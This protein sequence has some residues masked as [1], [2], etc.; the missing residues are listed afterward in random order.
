MATLPLR[1]FVRYAEAFPGTGRKG[2]FLG[3]I[4]LSAAP[5]AWRPW[6]CVY[7]RLAKI[8]AFMEVVRYN[9]DSY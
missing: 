5:S 3:E 2:L 7:A 4:I 6:Q 1:G 9:E 8:E